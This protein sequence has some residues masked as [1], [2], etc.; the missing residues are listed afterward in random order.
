MII[1]YIDKNG[2]F[3][4]LETLVDKDW[5]KKIEKIG[6]QRF[7]KRND[8]VISNA[9]KEIKDDSKEVVEASSFDEASAKEYLKEKGVR[10]YGLLKGEGL[11]K[12]AIEEGFII[13]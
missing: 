13:Q 7:E 3:S 12:R 10:G 5:D 8:V 4:I 9:K 6:L 11:K 1:K 2:N